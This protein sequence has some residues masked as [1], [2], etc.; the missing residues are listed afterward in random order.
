MSAAYVR[1]MADRLLFAD[2]RPMPHPSHA[3]LDRYRMNQL[4]DT[5][6]RTV[7][8]HLLWCHSCRRIALDAAE[9]AK[10]VAHLIADADAAGEYI[11]TS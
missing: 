6:N 8:N 4:C 7:K 10:L 3:D 11:K 9:L 1:H 5:E 2:I